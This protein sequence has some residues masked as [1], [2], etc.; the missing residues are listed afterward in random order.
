[1]MS[2]D[3]LNLT[4]VQ[5]T[6]LLPLWGRANETKKDNPLLI[7][8][9]AVR[10]IESIGYDFSIIE[11]KVNPLSCASWIARS[12]Y[13]DDHIRLFLSQYPDGSIINI[14]C[15]LDTTYDRINNNRA[16][17]Y[18]IDFPEV[19]ELRKKFIPETSTRRFV[20]CSVLDPEWYNTIDNKKNVCIMIAGVI[21]YFDEG[22]VKKMFDKI[23]QEFVHSDIVVDY[24]SP[25]GVDIANKKVIKDNGMDKN[26][27]LK[28]GITDIHN[29][30]KWNGK[31]KVLQTMKMFKDHRRKYPVFKRLGMLISDALA[32]MSLAHLKIE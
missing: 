11:A 3:S 2:K 30:E 31:I 17:W 9:V 5:E 23:A 1:M 12:I 21:Y 28:W 16:I 19:I 26:A 14:G 27:C 13:F 10:L 22:Q 6:L 4:G 29:I 7:D 20:P 8:S 24:C 32:V 18:E 15:G 25:K